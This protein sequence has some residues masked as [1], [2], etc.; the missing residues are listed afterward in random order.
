M[1]INNIIYNDNK[2][3]T[4]A[5]P[6]I[7]KISIYL[8]NENL[9][10]YTY[11]KEY[12]KNDK[13]NINYV[14]SNLKLTFEQVLCKKEKVKSILHKKNDLKLV[15]EYIITEDKIEIITIDIKLQQIY[16]NN[17]IIYK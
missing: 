13:K 8:K 5:E 6:N 11:K 12:Q 17:K 15:I 16:S 9:N 2:S 7:K 1:S 3:G 10:I 14:L 4:T